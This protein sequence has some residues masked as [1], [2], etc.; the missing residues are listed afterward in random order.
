MTN[1]K[2]PMLK[3]GNNLKASYIA[4]LL[5][6]AGLYMATCAPGPLWQDSGMLQYRIWHN[7]IQGNLGLAL[8]HP[9]YHIIGIGINTFLS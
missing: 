8:S 2:Y 9:L 5:T 4:V 6:A 3:A 7:D 1:R